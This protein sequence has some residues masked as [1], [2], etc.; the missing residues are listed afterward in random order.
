MLLLQLPLRQLFDIR[1]FDGDALACESAQDAG[2]ANRRIR[3]VRSSAVSIVEDARNQRDDH[4]DASHGN[5]DG[6]D[7]LDEAVVL[8][9]N[10]N[11][12]G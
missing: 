1:L 4:G 10:A 5:D 6:K 3:A 12:A 9:Q 11:H 8:L 7:D 2:A